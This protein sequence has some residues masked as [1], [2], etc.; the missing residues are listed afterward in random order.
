[1][2]VGIG[3]GESWNDGGIIVPDGA[4]YVHVAVTVS[5]TQSKIY[6]NGVLQNTAN[7]TSSFNFSESTTMVIGSGAPSFSYWS[8]LSDLS[9]LDDL[10]VYNKTLTP[11]EIT[12]TMQ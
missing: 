5:P 11:T 9:V 4:T 1:M 7:Y 8:H 10:R 6:F 2:N 12:A 3:S